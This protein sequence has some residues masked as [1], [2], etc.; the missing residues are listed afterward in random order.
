VNA[1]GDPIITPVSI[2]S[3]ID[4]SVEQNPRAFQTLAT[5]KLQLLV[6]PL[7][8]R[9][10]LNVTLPIQKIF[11]N[12]PMNPVLIRHWLKH[13]DGKQ[14]G[15]MFPRAP[16]DFESRTL[17]IH[18]LKHNSEAPVAKRVNMHGNFHPRADGILPSAPVPTTVPSIQVD[19]NLFVFPRALLPH[20][21]LQ[22]FDPAVWNPQSYG[23]WAHLHT[24]FAP[25]LD[26]E[27]DGR[28]PSGSATVFRR[29]M[30]THFADCGLL[31]GDMWWKFGLGDILGD[32][33][34]LY[35]FMRNTLTDMF[36]IYNAVPSAPSLTPFFNAVTMGSGQ[37]VCATC[38]ATRLG[39]A[40]MMRC[41]CHQVYYCSVAC[42][43]A[44]WKVHKV[45][46]GVAKK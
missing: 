13:D 40:Q 20:P 21:A 30:H 16:L 45:V 4:A 46:C 11:D 10:I 36:F 42:Q 25:I 28:I 37:R 8:T 3:C 38:L 7:W 1:N 44:N 12:V 34:T 24:N 35:T 22:P 2:L 26:E 19:L 18:I 6:S 39:S 5:D 17:S 29:M 33:N 15:L 27:S 14:G 31:F 23:I 41:T 43:R 32:N 9:S